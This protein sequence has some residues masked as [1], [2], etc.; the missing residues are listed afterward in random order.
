MLPVMIRQLAQM[1][2]PPIIPGNCCPNPGCAESTIVPEASASMA[3][4]PIMSLAGCASCLSEIIACLSINQKD[5]EKTIC[6]RTVWPKQLN[7]A[8]LRRGDPVGNLLRSSLKE[9]CPWAPQVLWQCSILQHFFNVLEL[10]NS[11]TWQPPS[12][13]ACTALRQYGMLRQ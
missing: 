5:L 13:P 3:A 2:I 4:N 10:C 7:K 6:H 9:P 1:Q 12:L 11:H 8:M